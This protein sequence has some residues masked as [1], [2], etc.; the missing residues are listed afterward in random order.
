[1]N[2]FLLST[3]LAST[4]FISGCSKKTAFDFFS[5][6]EYYEKA[7]SNMR[8]G[9][10]MKNNESKALIHAVYLNKVDPEVYHGNEYFFISLHVIDEV[11]SLKDGGLKGSD[12]SLKIIEKIDIGNY[13]SLE[14]NPLEVKNI[15]ENDPLKKHMPITNRWSYLYLVRFED[16]SNDDLVLTLESERYGNIKLTFPKEEVYKQ[17]K[18]LFKTVQT[19]QKK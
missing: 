11:Y 1:M 7:L 10:L 2:K 4:L 15:H 18:S 9:S 6:D 3:L 19:N 8:S 14:V 5:T 13:S 12:Y 17:G 16:I